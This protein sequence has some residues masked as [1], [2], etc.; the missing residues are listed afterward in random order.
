M[1][2]VQLSL[3]YLVAPSSKRL[4]SDFNAHVGI[5]DGKPLPSIASLTAPV[6]KF[7]IDPLDGSVELSDVI[8][9]FY[10]YFF[11]KKG[12]RG[13]TKT[14]LPPIAHTILL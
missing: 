2:I 11:K 8:I 13:N 5:K 12:E 10:L 14:P 9:L 3:P 1:P 6:E 7:V 4:A